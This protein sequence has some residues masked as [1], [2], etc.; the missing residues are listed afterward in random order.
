MRPA[1]NANLAVRVV[2]FVGSIPFGV[3]VLIAIFVYC[4]LGSAG[5]WPLPDSL[6]RQ[7]VEKTE[8]EW[9][10]WWPFNT[11]IAL[12]CVSVS[13]VTLRK[14]PF[15]LPRLGVW[16]VHCGIL[17][18]SLGSFIYFGQKIEGDVAVFR[19][20]LVLKSPDG[21]ET[22]VLL[23]PGASAEL[24]APGRRYE[25]R[26]GEINPNYE[27]LT[28][29]DKGKKTA[30]VQLMIRS[31][32]DG[33]SLEPFI[34]QLLVDYPQYTE[35]V[36]PGRGRAIKTLGKK[37]VDD[38]LSTELRYHQVDHFFVKDT[39]AIHARAAGASTWSEWELE[40]VPRY[41]GYI[42]SEQGVWDPIAADSSDRV[43][44]LEIEAKLRA[45]D[46]AWAGLSMRVTG[47]LP[48][49]VMEPRWVAG[50]TQ[51]FPMVRFTLRSESG[52][53][54]HTLLADDPDARRE[55]LGD[56]FDASFRWIDDPAELEALLKPGEP[57][58]LVRIPSRR[59]EQRLRLADA[60][61]QPVVIGDSGYSIQG[62]E[63]YPNWSLAGR[64]RVGERA[65]M[66]LIRITGPQGTIM[67]GV[68]APHYELS[69]DLD[70]QGNR[71]GGLIDREIEVEA[72]NIADAG[73]MLIGGR[74]GA[75]ALLVSQ[76]GEVQH[77][78]VTI[79]QEVEFLD[80]VLRLTVDELS[81]NARREE[82]PRLIPFAQRDL[83]QLPFYSLIQVELREA[84]GAPVTAWLP[85]SAY[86]YPTRQGFFPIEVALP[87]GRTVE[88]LYSRQTHPLSS[89]V[90][91]E[92][93][94]LETFPGGTRERD[95]ISL[96]RFH[97]NGGWSDVHQVHSNNPTEHAD[98]WYFQATWDPPEPQSG[99]AGM[100]FTG[101]GVGNRKGVWVMLA[102]S[103]LMAFGTIWAFYI[104]PVIIR[105][106]ARQGAERRAATASAATL[107]L[108]VAVLSGCASNATKPIE[109][110]VASEFSS[111]LELDPMRHAAVLDDGRIKTFETLAR[112][113]IKHVNSLATRKGDAVLIY[114]DLL[115]SA[116]HH[117]SS[118]SILIRKVPFRRELIRA[119]RMTVPPPMR[120]GVLAEPELERIETSGRVSAEFLD[121]PA[122]RQ[123]LSM[124]ERDLMRT[125]KE[126]ISLGNARMLMAPENLL[127]M[128]RAIPPPGG[129]D[130]DPWFP[131][132]AVLRSSAAPADDVHSTVSSGAAGIPGLAAETAQKLRNSWDA[133]SRAWRF[134]DA[135]AA[136]QAMKG[137]LAGFQQA[138]PELYP[139]A[140]RLSWETWYHRSY[141]LTWVWIIY[142]AA[143]PFLLMAAVLKL[144]WP[145]RVGLALFLIGFALHTLAIGVRWYLA[146]RI[147]NANMFEAITASAW[148]GGLVAMILELIVR[149]FP[150]K[151]LFALAAT[152]YAMFAMM[153][154]YFQPVVLGSSPIDNDI[155]TVMPVLDR[156]IWL[157]IHT[158][159]IIAS[160]ALIFFG[161]VTALIWLVM[162]WVASNGGW[163]SLLSSWSG[164]GDLEARAGGAASLMLRPGGFVG[165]SNIGLS[166]T[167]D[168]ATM[169]FMELSFLTLLVGT[170]LGAVWA[171]V[172]WGRPWG[173]DPKEVFALNTWLVFLVLVHVRLKVSRKA[174]WTAV[175]AVIGCAVML[176]NWLCV[177]FV[178]VGLHSYA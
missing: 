101:L 51:R 25:V 42:P 49:A 152:T 26:V 23:Q 52:P 64:G 128:W 1:T 45:P 36:L 2:D 24:V 40:G 92:V 118:P 10:S 108:L 19:R 18:L 135:E 133:L 136:N 80:G 166:K 21:A 110:S 173:W 3:G 87:S 119:V 123:A 73:L 29:A 82:R 88:L 96:V 89:P 147:P 106:L 112:E 81:E 117:Y 47:Y 142:L 116:E 122:V 13:L 143:V 78:P 54:G 65:S 9:F 86:N 5:L 11:L 33:Q 170:V 131:L 132:S 169:I 91:L 84:G 32:R 28:G 35:D 6:V 30:S 75:H 156:T 151:N 157:Y 99:H 175:I 44:P 158:N 163:P 71:A 168:G 105:R 102:G 148:L 130:H 121:Q 107:S 27:L 4:W 167:L 139:S 79:G 126:S 8:M 164:D 98:W 70:D 68:V 159:M 125:S 176:F 161:S 120:Q 150:V 41:H 113:R 62:L 127:G 109:L 144:G 76:R 138:A 103:I 90:A 115:L 149:R 94:Q 177:N 7:W 55:T 69:Q 17:V 59:I 66:V 16:I 165:S 38:Q 140:S 39:V 85:Y 15:S 171:D 172:S 160:Y 72:R 104:K 178:I 14:I 50:G 31:E 34:R 61:A 114:L 124:L 53:S 137:L 74:E 77:R 155:T 20:E 43:R 22:A 162:N 100:N 129:T 48:F 83:K 57:E 111:A 95:Y 146:G 56:Q 67:R 37:L 145:R 174:Y 12:L 153:I 134:Q 63:V 60:M 46:P 93:F 154:G 97:E 58:L 141:K